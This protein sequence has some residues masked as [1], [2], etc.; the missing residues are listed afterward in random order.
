[1]SALANVRRS[2]LCFAVV[3]ALGFAAACGGES[4]G[5]GTDAVLAEF[6]PPSQPIDHELLAEGLSRAQAL[7]SDD[8]NLSTFA[9]EYNLR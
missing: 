2:L 8:R 7:W 4:S 1:M 3:A 5:N 6:I 9:I